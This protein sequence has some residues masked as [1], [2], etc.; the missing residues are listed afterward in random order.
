MAS[1]NAALTFAKASSLRSRNCR[2]AFGL[3]LRPVSS[4]CLLDY[5][6]NLCSLVA[7][8]FTKRAQNLLSL[9]SSQARELRKLVYEYELD[10]T[11][12]QMIVCRSRENDFDG[13]GRDA[14]G[15]IAFPP[16]TCSL[17]PLDFVASRFRR[18]FPK[19]SG[20]RQLAW[21]AAKVIDAEQISV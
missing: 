4:I 1:R 7:G 11:R 16:L 3:G 6:C 9:Q 12:V 18:A 21:P 20:R 17:K 2:K 5:I 15:F 10:L 8:V 13:L 19:I 14:H